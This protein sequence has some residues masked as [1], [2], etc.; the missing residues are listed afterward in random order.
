MDEETKR[1]AEKIRARMGE[2]TLDLLRSNDSVSL[3]ELL[4]SFEDDLRRAE[5]TG[6]RDGR[7]EASTVIRLLRRHFGLD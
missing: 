2:R 5:E 6:A 4:G 1:T 7:I 3:Q